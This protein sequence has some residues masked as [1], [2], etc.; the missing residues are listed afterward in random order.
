MAEW[1]NSSK[2]LGKYIVQLQNH[3]QLSKIRL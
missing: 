3:I 1:E 2:A